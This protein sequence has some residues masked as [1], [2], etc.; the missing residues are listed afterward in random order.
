MNEQAVQDRW[1]V[2]LED[3]PPKSGVPKWVWG[4]GGGCLLMLVA[5]IATTIFLGNL[6][7]K[8]FGPEAAWPVVAEVMPY[9][10][11]GSFEDVPELR[12]PGYEPG[13]FSA[14]NPFIGAFLSDEEVASLPFEHIVIFPSLMDVSQPRGTGVNL[15]V[16]IFPDLIEGDPASYVFES[17]LMDGIVVDRDEA[18]DLG[19]RRLTFQGREVDTLHRVVEFDQGQQIFPNGEGFEEMLLIDATGDRDRTVVLV[20]VATG[21]VGATIESAEEF[22]LPFRVWDGR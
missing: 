6:A 14:D 17:P 1:D 10:D 19:A 7:R 15:T 16:I 12:P 18:S 9:G 13:K 22:A 3:A 8:H 20:F 4:C 5:L 21:E 2:E 11:E